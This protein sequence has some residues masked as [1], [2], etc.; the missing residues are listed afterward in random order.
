[1]MY[2]IY[3]W[4]CVCVCV[5]CV[6]MCVCGVYMCV[7]VRAVCACVYV[8]VCGVCMC[9]RACVRCVRVR[10]CVCARV[11][12][13]S[14]STAVRVKRRHNCKSWNWEE[15][16]EVLCLQVCLSKSMRRLL[17]VTGTLTEMRIQNVMN[18]SRSIFHR[19]LTRS[20]T[21]Q[22]TTLSQE[23]PVGIQHYCYHLPVSIE[24]SIRSEPRIT[25]NIY[26]S[27]VANGKIL[28]V[29]NLL[30][31]GRVGREGYVFQPSANSMWGNSMTACF[32]CVPRGCR[33]LISQKA[34]VNTIAWL[35]HY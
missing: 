21:R 28:C 35:L 2:H 24:H 6:C 20:V 19:A 17:T 9:V 27:L 15:W 29:W 11:I 13:G 30:L 8:C 3:G 10:M 25:H 18:N 1:M 23:L 5:W 22:N 26:S 4:Q 31:C 7:C 32:M 14:L 12:D 34:A 33:T 16:R